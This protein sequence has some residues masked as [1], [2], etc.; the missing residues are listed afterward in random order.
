VGCKMTCSWATPIVCS[1]SYTQHLYPTPC[2]TPYSLLPTPLLPTPTSYILHVTS[3]TPATSHTLHPAHYNERE[4]EK[5]K[6]TK[7]QRALRYSTCIHN[8]FFGI[9]QE[10]MQGI[11]PRRGFLLHMLDWLSRQVTLCVC[12]A[13]CLFPT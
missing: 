4:R 13:P 10:K 12:S 7:R 1:V 5:E 3:C 2:P 11:R 6:G 8:S 9:L